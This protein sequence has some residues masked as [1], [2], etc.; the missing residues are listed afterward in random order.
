[1]VV[2]NKT[3]QYY[4]EDKL[5]NIWDDVR[6]EIGLSKSIRLYDVT[7]HSV[8][9]QLVNKGVPLLSVSRLLGHS[10]TKMTER[11]A[12]TDL[13]K[14]KVDIAN[15]SLQGETVTKLSSEEKTVL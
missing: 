10:N 15:L 5:R 9:S 12:H 6:E 13:E 1:M 11:Y 3:G 8:A 4:S 7:R 2:K 14:L